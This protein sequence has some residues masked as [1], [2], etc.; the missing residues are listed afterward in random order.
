M[1]VGSVNERPTSMPR[2]ILAVGHS[3]EYEVTHRL[4]G[5]MLTIDDRSKRIAFNVA[6]CENLKE[7]F[8]PLV[9]Y[10]GTG[11]HDGLLVSNGTREE[12]LSMVD[13]PLLLCEVGQAVTH[14][15]MELGDGSGPTV[16]LCKAATQ[17]KLRGSIDEEPVLGVFLMWTLGLP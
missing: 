5:R 10:R 9:I 15:H 7:F 4:E 6:L 1:E 14:L 16:V 8:N 11:L 3:D 17:E 12:G 13:D 2:G